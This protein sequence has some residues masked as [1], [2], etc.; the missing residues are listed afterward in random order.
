[1]IQFKFIYCV[2]RYFVHEVKV[3]LPD[4]ANRK[5]ICGGAPK[6]FLIPPKALAFNK[7]SYED[8]CMF[9][10]GAFKNLKNDANLA[11]L[12]QPVS[13]TSKQDAPIGGSKHDFVSIGRYWWPNPKTKNKLPYIRRD[14]YVNPEFYTYRDKTNLNGMMSAVE[15]LSLHHYFAHAP[16]YGDHAVDLLDAWF[17]NDDTK[18]TPHLNFAGGIP[19]VCDGRSQGIIA[20]HMLP[21]LID[22]IGILRYTG[23]L[24]ERRFEQLKSWFANYFDWLV[25][26]EFGK[27]EAAAKNNHGTWYD[28]QVLSLALFLD[29]KDIVDLIISKIIPSRIESQLGGLGEQLFETERA[30]SLEYSLFNLSAYCW[31]T[32]MAKTQG[33]DL[34][35][36]TLRSGKS[37][38]RALD[39]LIPFIFEKEPWPYKQSSALKMQKVYEILISA[40]NSFSDM[41]YLDLL[42][43][44]DSAAKD[45]RAI[46][47]FPDIK[48]LYYFEAILSGKSAGEATYIGEA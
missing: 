18:M 28:V 8:Q 40:L 41:R 3:T 35:G 37:L 38:Q 10:K 36:L 12:F 43:Q 24:D 16:E 26:S 20:M 15:A 1:M 4:S 11:M 34:W 9:F 27:K 39:F 19:G 46:F 2:C 48:N 47:R 6:T 17:L 44:I 42:D 5:G 14:G 22:A 33:V 45:G 29:K 31:I 32:N 30:Q 21:K 13:V 23:K 25:S 7:S